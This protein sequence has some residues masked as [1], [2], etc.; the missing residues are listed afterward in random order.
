MAFRREAGNSLEDHLVLVAEEV[1]GKQ[2]VPYEIPGV[3]IQHQ[4][5]QDTLFSL[6]RMRRGEVEMLHWPPP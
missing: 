2:L 4:A 1:L 5:A 3:V 6:H